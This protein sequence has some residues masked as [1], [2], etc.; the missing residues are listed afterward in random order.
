VDA[1]HAMGLVED[2]EID[3]L[4]G[5][6]L[7]RDGEAWARVRARLQPEVLAAAVCAARAGAPD[8]DL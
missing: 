5:L 6:I 3:H 4:P 8:P 7:V 2:W 1:L